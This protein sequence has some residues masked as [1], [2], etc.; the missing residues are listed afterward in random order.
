MKSPG[1]LTTYTFR[2]KQF[3][4]A[5]NVKEAKNPGDEFSVR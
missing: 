3:S 4:M 1:H 2:H 5:K